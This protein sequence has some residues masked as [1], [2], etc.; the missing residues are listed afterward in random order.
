MNVSSQRNLSVHP[1]FGEGQLS[2]EAL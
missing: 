2:T 1:G